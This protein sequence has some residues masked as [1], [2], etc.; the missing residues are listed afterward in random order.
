MNFK[1]KRII[2]I[3][4]AIIATNILLKEINKE[5]FH[6]NL[7]LKI[8]SKFLLVIIT[9]VL[10]LK[11]SLLV[12]YKYNK[13]SVFL[14][15]ISFTATLL[16]FL[17][18]NNEIVINKL[19]IDSYTHLL[20]LTSCFAVGLF[21]ELFF[22]VFMFLFMLKIF[23]KDSKGLFKSIILTSI[24]FGIA[25]YSNFLNPEYYK[26]AVINQSL[27]AISIGIL[28]QS[29]YVRFNSLIFIVTI[30]SLINY[31]GSYKSQLFKINNDYNK[32]YETGDFLSTLMS[33]VIFSIFV[34]IV[35]YFLVRQK[36][37]Y[38]D[39]NTDFKNN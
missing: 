38:C 35:S 10:L 22:R 25:H 24:F 3:F 37:S 30:H 16:A 33:I 7:L 26:L 5:F 23:E 9:I 13:I 6:D 18:I 17:A 14:T 29:I 8:I 12:R 27:F 15:I 2:I 36:K 11:H 19:I 20:F 32:D 31:L 28:L 21:E 1:L 4:V 34:F 39:P